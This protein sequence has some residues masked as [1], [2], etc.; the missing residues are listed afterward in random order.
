VDILNEHAKNERR[1]R[2][3]LLQIIVEDWIMDH[4][5]AKVDTP[6][7]PRQ[8]WDEFARGKVL[9]DSPGPEY[10]AERTE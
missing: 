9:V 8:T 4:A 2:S 5:A 10:E 1:T 7:P 3:N 6:A